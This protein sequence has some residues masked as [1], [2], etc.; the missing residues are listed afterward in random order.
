MLFALQLINILL[1]QVSLSFYIKDNKTEDSYRFVTDGHIS[2]SFLLELH[3]MR[4]CQRNTEISRVWAPNSNGFKNLSTDLDN[5]LPSRTSHFTKSIGFYVGA[6]VHTIVCYVCV[7]LID[8]WTIRGALK[9]DTDSDVAATEHSRCK[10]YCI[11]I[12]N[13]F[14]ICA[15][16]TASSN[17]SCGWR[18]GLFT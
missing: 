12:G 18:S 4:F 14:A 9:M 3:L 11:R 5:V 10:R 1:F 16:S 2:H 6:A 8:S 7:L 13:K 17:G 15:W